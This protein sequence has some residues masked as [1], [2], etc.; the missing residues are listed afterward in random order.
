MLDPLMKSIFKTFH[1]TV[2]HK[3]NSLKKF[4]HELNLYSVY[5]PQKTHLCYSAFA[6]QTCS[7]CLSR[8]PKHHVTTRLYLS[9]RLHVKSTLV[10]EAALQTLSLPP[11]DTRARKVTPSRPD[12]MNTKS[13]TRA[14]I[15]KIILI[16]F[17]CCSKFYPTSPKSNWVHIEL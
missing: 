7:W 5:L 14:Y 15:N 11:I 3:D 10:N 17:H 16:Y 6:R 8:A 1:S 2:E 9:W 4:N 12:F 13:C